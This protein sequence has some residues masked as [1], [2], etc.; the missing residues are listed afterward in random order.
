[1]EKLLSAV[2]NMKSAQDGYLNLSHMFFL[3]I[4]NWDDAAIYDSSYKQKELVII[5]IKWG[6]STVPRSPLHII[7]PII[8]SS[9]V[10]EETSF[11][12]KKPNSFRLSNVYRENL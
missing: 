2:Q 5:K 6:W 9:T 4:Y 1:M 7:Q 10:L 3:A 12:Q 11:F 8:V